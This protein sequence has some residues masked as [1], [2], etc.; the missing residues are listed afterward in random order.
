MVWFVNNMGSPCSAEVKLLFIMFDFSLIPLG[1]VW[2]P[3]PAMGWIA[4]SLSFYKD[5]LG[6]KLEKSKMIVFSFYDLQENFD[7]YLYLIFCTVYIFSV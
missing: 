2:A 5:G 3:T 7:Y 6:I 4:L 1:K